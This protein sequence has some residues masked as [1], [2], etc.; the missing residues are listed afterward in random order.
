MENSVM[1]TNRR[2][3]VIQWGETDPASI[4]F[5]PNYFTWFDESTCVLFEAVGLDWNVLMQKFGVVG[6]PIVEA[7]ATFAAPCM[8]RDRIVIETSL[9]HWGDKTFH[10]NHVVLYDEKPAVLGHEVRAWATRDPKSPRGMKALP[11]PKEVR[12]AFE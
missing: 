8:F 2:S 12:A 9:D 3:L 11:I 6:F 7:K 5:Y 4:V 10:V 1:R